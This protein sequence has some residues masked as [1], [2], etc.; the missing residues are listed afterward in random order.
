MTAHPRSRGENRPIL[1]PWIG[2]AGSSP[3][4]RG[5]LSIAA[6]NTA[7]MGL[8]P[9]HAGKTS[10]TPRCRHRARAHPRSR[11]EN[12]LGMPETTRLQGSSPL[13]RG[14]RRRLDNLHGVLGLIPA[15]AGK[16]LQPM[17]RRLHLGAHPRSRG[18]NEIARAEDVN[19]NGSSPLTRGKPPFLAIAR[20]LLGLIPAHA[21]KTWFHQSHQADPRAHPRSRGENIAAASAPDRRPGS[22]PLTRGKRGA[23]PTCSAKPGLIPAHAGKT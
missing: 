14:K 13:T 21:G 2:V 6:T 1:A 20:F 10:R 4:T 23:C 5:K 15:H 16:T 12:Q 18:E 11:G 9:A 7:P 19:S 3:L 22:S 17:G 8:I